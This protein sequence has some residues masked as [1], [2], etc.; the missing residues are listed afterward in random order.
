[1]VRLEGARRLIAATAAAAGI[2]RARPSAPS[3]GLVRLRSRA[4]RAW[5]WAPGP[6]ASFAPALCFAV[7]AAAGAGGVSAASAASARALPSIERVSVAGDGVQANGD[8]YSAALSGD[9]R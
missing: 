1:M 5:P 2:A 4:H 3:V 8:S 6:I 7:A 9:G